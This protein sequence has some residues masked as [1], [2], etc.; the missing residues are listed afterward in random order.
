MS[1]T[2]TYT[3]ISV[4]LHDLFYSGQ[5]Q[6]LVFERIHQFLDLLLVILLSTASTLLFRALLRYSWYQVDLIS[7]VLELLLNLHLILHI[8]RI[9]LCYRRVRN[10]L[11]I[12]LIVVAGTHLG[13]AHVA[14]W[15]I[16]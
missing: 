12:L 4:H 10:L 7:E 9:I 8:G 13:H 1:G 15:L 3:N 2:A 5:G 16:G 14:I 11:L 6:L